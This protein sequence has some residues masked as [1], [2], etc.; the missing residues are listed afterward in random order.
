[1]RSCA[2]RSLNLNGPAHTGWVPNLSPSACAA[3]G[4][5]IMLERET[6]GKRINDRD[7]VEGGNIALALRAGQGGVS[8]QAEPGCLGVE[9]RAVVEF[10]ALAQGDRQSL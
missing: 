4:E 1:M 3:L 6:N 2:T 8:L 9:I 7:F 5:T 10:H